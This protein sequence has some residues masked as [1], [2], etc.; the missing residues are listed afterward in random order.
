MPMSRMPPVLLIWALMF[1]LDHVSVS[2]NGSH[3][4]T[5]TGPTGP[6]PGCFCAFAVEHRAT[7]RDISF[8]PNVARKW[9]DLISGDLL[10]ERASRSSG[11]PTRSS[12]VGSAFVRPFREAVAKGK[13]ALRRVDSAFAGG[14]DLVPD[15]KF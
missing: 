1:A 5:A 13:P 9:H 6:T 4:P 10:G 12:I 3:S 15:S 14:R 7:S 11:D 8:P 2:K